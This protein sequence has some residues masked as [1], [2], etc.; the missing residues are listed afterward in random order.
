MSIFPLAQFEA[1]LKTA[2]D[3]EAAYKRLKPPT[4]IVVRFGLMRLVGEFP[5]TGDQKPGCGSKMVVRTFRGTEIGEMLTSTCPNAGCS[6]SVTRQEMLE[7]IENSGGKDYP[8][9]TDGR[10]LRV[11]TAEDMSE[12]SRLDAQK[13]PMVRRAREIAVELGLPMK[14]VDAEPILGG[15]RLTFYFASEERIDFRDMVHLLAQDFGA[16]IEMRQI[17]ARD[18]ARITADYERCGQH[19]CCKQ[20]L[21]VLKPVS[22]RSA[23]TQKASLDPLKISGRCGRLMCCL[24]Y[25]DATYEELRKRL[26]NMKSRVGTAH[27]VGIVLDRQILTQLVQVQLEDDG[28]MVAVAVEELVDPNDE[29]AMREAKAKGA[30]PLRGETPERAARRG[31]GSRDSRAATQD[32]H[33][34]QSEREVMGTVDPGDFEHDVEM[35]DDDPAAPPRLSER[36]SRG[37][38]EGE[39]GTGRKRSRRRRGRGGGSKS[40][41]AS[42]GGRRSQRAPGQGR[43]AGDGSPPTEGSP[44]A[45]REG[46]SG[47]S[48][49]EGGAPKK[50]RR[51]RRRRPGGGGG[52]EGGGG[53]APSGGE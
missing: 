25:E 38:A 19:C 21:K 44:P 31:R 30:D 48:D 1:D 33:R 3:D 46:G 27:G 53:G 8:F 29:A 47:A 24:R 51:R 22:M 26:P 2:M 12:Q 9:F 6:K 52:G 28:T 23:K 41:G 36:P 39:A 35:R 40:D 7:Y 43:P 5:Y 32:A 14:V 10:V 4:S 45:P 42:G 50:R 37:P 18:E 20:F 11:A 17:G 49:G 13:M 15:E 16:R 34:D